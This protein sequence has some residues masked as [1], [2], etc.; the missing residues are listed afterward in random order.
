[1]NLTNDEKKPKESEIEPA[2]NKCITELLI[3]AVGYCY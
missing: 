1:M 3:M 2:I